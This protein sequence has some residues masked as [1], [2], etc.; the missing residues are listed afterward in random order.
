MV[1]FDQSRHMLLVGHGVLVLDPV[2]NVDTCILLISLK[3][4]YVRVCC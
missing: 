1:S 4:V 3:G 2:H